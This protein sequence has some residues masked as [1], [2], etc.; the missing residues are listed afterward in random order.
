[1]FTKKYIRTELQNLDINCIIVE[2]KSCLHLDYI[3]SNEDDRRKL[4]EWI[5]LTHPTQIS[6][7]VILNNNCNIVDISFLSEE[8]GLMLKDMSKTSLFNFYKLELAIKN[9]MSSLINIFK[10]KND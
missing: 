3:V 10:K 5:N 2:Y 7:C 6:K 4:Q 1:M 9:F 8:I